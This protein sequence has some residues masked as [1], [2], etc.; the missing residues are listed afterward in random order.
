M[1][2]FLSYFFIGLVLSGISPKEGGAG[3]PVKEKSKRKSD[4]NTTL[5]PVAKKQKTFGRSLL[6][7]AVMSGDLRRVRALT[8]SLSPAQINEQD[9]W[10]NSALHRAAYGG[11]VAIIKELTKKLNPDQI[12]RKNKWGD[13]PLHAAAGSGNVQAIEALARHLTSEQINERIDTLP[14]LKDEDSANARFVPESLPNKLLGV[15]E[16]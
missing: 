12:N 2:H 8:Q 11:K 7:Q 1:P 5:E 3:D 9:E 15:T 4:H 13:T 14:V 10:G 16:L 6:H